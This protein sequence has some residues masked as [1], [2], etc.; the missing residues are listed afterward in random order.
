MDIHLHIMKVKCFSIQDYVGMQK[1]LNE[2]GWDGGADLIFSDLSI[3]V[4]IMSEGIRHQKEKM[5]NLK[6]A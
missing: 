1:V 2:V 6:K 4:E 3:M 5:S